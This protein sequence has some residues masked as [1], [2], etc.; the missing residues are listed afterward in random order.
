MFCT[1][2]ND[3][4]DANA[5]G[6]Q[7]ARVASLVGITPTFVGV[8]EKLNENNEY[9]R[10]EIEA[11]GCL[12]DILDATEGK[13]GLVLVNVANRHAKGK[14]WSNGTPFGYFWFRKTVVVTTID[15][16]VLALIKKTGISDH[17]KVMDIDK[18]MRYL[19]EKQ[20]CSED[21]AEYMNY[22]Q[23]RSYDF[24]PRVGAYLLKNH[25]VPHEI[26]YFANA[27]YITDISGKI[28]YIDNFGNVK[29]TVVPE[30][31][32]FAN[33]KKI[34]TTI[35]EVPCYERLKDV[36]NNETAMVIGSSGIGN[37]RFLE[38]VTQGMSAA[39]KYSLHVGQKI[40]S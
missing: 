20:V 10:A 19:V 33:G 35:G 14:R 16:A 37:K 5:V 39:D 9:D 38:L 34:Q 29:T 6:R 2:I 24:S 11:A 25:D 36:P 13:E 8:G 21:I 1:I 12:L 23:F 18:V 27:N 26:D 30:E 22:T 17:I 40:I 15:G 31:V 3:C 7:C 28:W 32:N 4:R